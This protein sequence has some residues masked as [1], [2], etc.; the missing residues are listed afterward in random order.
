MPYPYIDSMS[1]QGRKQGKQGTD[2]KIAA[3]S[4]SR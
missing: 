2:A 3:V 4:S 1:E